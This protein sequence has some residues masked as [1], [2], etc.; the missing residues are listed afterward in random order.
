MTIVS[1]IITVMSRH[2]QDP[3]NND[4]DLLTDVELVGQTLVVD[5]LHC[6]LGGHHLLHR[7][8]VQLSAALR[9]EIHQDA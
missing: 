9:V 1:V 4:D 8:Q 2:A 6:P 3:D 5:H 7:V